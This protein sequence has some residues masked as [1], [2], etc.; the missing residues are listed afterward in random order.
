[1]SGRMNRRARCGKA[2]AVTRG[3][4]GQTDL[5]RK[6]WQLP[7]CAASLDLHNILASAVED[8]VIDHRR[9]DTRAALPSQTHTT[10]GKDE[11]AQEV[12]RLTAA[13][14]RHAAGNADAA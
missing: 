7:D 1:M 4:A 5:D 8:G 14:A 6:L 9:T 3:G 10:D 2:E 12:V 13:D 11:T